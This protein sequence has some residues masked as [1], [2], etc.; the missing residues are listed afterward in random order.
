MKA[1]VVLV[2]VIV[3]AAS[4][5]AYGRA[6]VAAGMAA[7]VDHTPHTNEPIALLLSG[8]GLIGLA[9]ALRRFA[10]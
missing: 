3:A 5:V 1:L 7:V 8:S 4:L 6:D 2:L 10:F 9:G